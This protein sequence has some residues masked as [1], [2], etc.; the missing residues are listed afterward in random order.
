MYLPLWKESIG[1]G[2]LKKGGLCSNARR[3]IFRWWKFVKEHQSVDFPTSRFHHVRRWKFKDKSANQEKKEDVAEHVQMKP[4][5]ST[6]LHPSVS[7]ATLIPGRV[8]YSID[9]CDT[10]I[11]PASDSAGTRGACFR[12]RASR[13]LTERVEAGDVLCWFLRG[14]ESP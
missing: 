7:D 6:T 5:F 2:L 4:P 13:G 9:A 10:I 1:R 11:P 3:P 12:P 14:E 8:A